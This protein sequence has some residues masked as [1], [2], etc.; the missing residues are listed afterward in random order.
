MNLF[1]QIERIDESKGRYLLLTDY[2]TEGISIEGQYETPEEAI[3][4]YG[5]DFPQTIVYLPE[6]DFEVLG[7]N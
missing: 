7:G 1:N 3:M 5:S 6:F 4:A 2:R